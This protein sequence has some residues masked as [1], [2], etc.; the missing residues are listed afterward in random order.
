[1][2]NVIKNARFQQRRNTSEYW[3]LNPQFVP[4]AGEIIIYTD[5]RIVDGRFKPAIKIGDGQTS[6]VSLPFVTGSSDGS[7]DEFLHE[8]E[9]HINDD[10]K[11]VT[12]KERSFW[13]GKLNYHMDGETL[14]FT[15]E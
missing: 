1:M 15:T 2:P 3:R 5:Y 12:E 9:E 4:L 10:S 8:L 7:A 13:N 6:I 14:V 11:H